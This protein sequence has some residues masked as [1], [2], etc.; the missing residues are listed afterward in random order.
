[1]SCNTCFVLGAGFSSSAKLPTQAEILKGFSPPEM[2][3]VCKIFGAK[4]DTKNIRSVTLEDVFTFLDKIISANETAYYVDSGKEKFFE[5]KEAYEMRQSLIETII[6]QFESKQ[7]LAINKPYYKRFFDEMVRRK[8]TGHGE[9][10]TI[11]TLNWDTLSEFYINRAFKAYPKLKGGVDYGCY[12]W[13][14][15]D[16]SGYV[17]SIL[18]KTSGWKT[19]KVLKLHGSVNWVYS[20][21]N[22]SIG[23]REQ[24]KTKPEVVVISRETGKEYAKEAITSSCPQRSSKT[25]EMST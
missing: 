20:K 3:D 12:D 15:D 9:T 23:I 1:M 24:T 21:R 8:A 7:R 2:R 10:N 5:V 13:D 25:L 18:R 14:A 16:K 22:G 11:V 19:I 17:P 4:A 6:K